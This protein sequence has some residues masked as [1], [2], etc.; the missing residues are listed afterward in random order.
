MNPF[1]DIPVPI[2]FTCLGHEDKDGGPGY[3]GFKPGYTFHPERILSLVKGIS[4]GCP[5]C[6]A[7]KDSCT[8]RER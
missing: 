2:T 4:P 1:P 5:K 6:W 7:D 3:S 8:P